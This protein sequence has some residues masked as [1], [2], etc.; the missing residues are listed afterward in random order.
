MQFYRKKYQ[1]HVWNKTETKTPFHVWKM[2]PKRF[3]VF[4]SYLLD[5]ILLV[6]SQ[7]RF[8]STRQCTTLPEGGGGGGGAAEGLKS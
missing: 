7:Y 8:Q 1:V 5:H 2:G 4:C 3:S 6:S